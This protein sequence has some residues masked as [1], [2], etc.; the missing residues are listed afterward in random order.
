[1]YNFWVKPYMKKLL[2]LPLIMLCMQVF[3]QKWKPV[4]LD[5]LVS[6]SMPEG[7]KEKDTLGQKTYSAEA[8]IGY[9]IANKS[10]GAISEQTKLRS[11]KDLEAVY[12]GYITSVTQAAK[13]QPSSERDTT[14]GS[15]KGKNFN[16]IADGEEGPEIRNFT[17]VL[18]GKDMYSFEFLQKQIHLAQTKENRDKFFNSIKIADVSVKD[19]LTSAGSKLSKEEKKDEWKRYGILAGV[20]IAIVAVVI[21]IMR[22]RKH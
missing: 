12:K 9:I 20:V 10:P 6:V 21:L 1:M 11:E 3:A 13:A 15:I 5:S 7:F 18:V 4:K 17:V 8:S 14:I 16:I 22:M 2:F 19:Q